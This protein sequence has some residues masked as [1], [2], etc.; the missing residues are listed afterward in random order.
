MILELKSLKGL[1]HDVSDATFLGLGQ[2]GPKDV[3]AKQFGQIVTD[4]NGDE[5]SLE[6]V[7]KAIQGQQDHFIRL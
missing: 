5:F 1:V 6:S 7:P 3:L 4:L 2:A